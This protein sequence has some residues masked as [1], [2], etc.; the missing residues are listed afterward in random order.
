MSMDY[1]SVRAVAK[2]DA[3]EVK[4][5]LSELNPAQ[6]KAESLYTSLKAVEEQMKD[7]L[8]KLGYKVETALGNRNNRISLAVYD[9]ES[10]K[11]L[12]GV[13]LD[14]DAFAAS[15][16]CMERDVYK[17]RFL[18]SRGWTVMRV[19]CR[20]WWLSPAKVVKSIAAVAEKNKK[21]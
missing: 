18:E 2:D 21:A 12:V 15:A 17:P 8:E 5:I 20:D 4:V 1:I 19:W 16:S 9:P 14:K 11:Y 13:E 3:E 7:R 10:D 6:T